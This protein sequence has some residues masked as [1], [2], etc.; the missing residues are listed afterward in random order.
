MVVFVNPLLAQ[1]RVAPIDLRQCC[2]YSSTHVATLDQQPTP[3]LEEAEAVSLVLVAL[4]ALWAISVQMW[5]MMV[6]TLAI[7]VQMWVILDGKQATKV[8]KLATKVRKQATKVRKL[9]ILAGSTLA[10]VQTH[11][12]PVW[13]HIDYPAPLGDRAAAHRRLPSVA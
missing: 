5:V 2:H 4:V 3:T 1:A 8:R 7:S 12:S 9:E 10:V 11:Q 13:L 6:C